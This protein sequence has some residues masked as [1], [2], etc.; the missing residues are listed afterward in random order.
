LDIRKALT[1]REDLEQNNHIYKTLLR[2]GVACLVHLLQ[3]VEELEVQFMW[4]QRYVLLPVY[5]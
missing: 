5:T 1:K 2:Q 3:G 4:A